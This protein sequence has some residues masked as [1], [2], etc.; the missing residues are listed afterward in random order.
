[1]NLSVQLALCMLVLL[2]ETNMWTPLLVLVIQLSSDG[3]LAHMEKRP[4]LIRRKYFLSIFKTYMVIKYQEFT[5]K[6]AML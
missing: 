2:S 3:A 4:R 6:P 1:M 5:T